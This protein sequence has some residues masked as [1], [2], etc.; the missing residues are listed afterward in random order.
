MDRTTAVS[1]IDAVA[2][3]LMLE[4]WHGSHVRDIDQ[5]VF[6]LG[7]VVTFVR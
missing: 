1:E 5:V 4:H 7:Y 6:V 3:W 2:V